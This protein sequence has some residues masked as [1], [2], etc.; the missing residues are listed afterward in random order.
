MLHPL[1]NL[2][3]Q[4]SIG[5][6]EWSS[7][8]EEAFTSCKQMLVDNSLVVHYD[9]KKG[10][11]LACDASCYGVGAMLSHVEENGEERPI[12]YVLRTMTSAERNY[13]QIEREGLALI[14]GMKKFHRYLY[15]RRFML[16]TDHK[17]LT[18]F[19]PKAGIPTLAAARLQRLALILSAYE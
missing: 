7:Q 11:K 9:S 6:W 17:P 3:Q 2:L 4:K 8:C 18:I 13:S 12:A 1:H 10:V 15:G 5:K 16:E 14:Y 19:G